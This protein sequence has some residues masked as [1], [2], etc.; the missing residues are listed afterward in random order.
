MRELTVLSC[1]VG[2]PARPGVRSICGTL[3]SGMPALD[4]AA[5]CGAL[6]VLD[7]MGTTRVV[8]VSRRHMYCSNGVRPRIRFCYGGYNGVVS[9]FSR[10]TPEMARAGIVSN[11]VIRRRRLCCG[12]VYSTYTGGVRGGA[13]WRRRGTRVVHRAESLVMVEWCGAEAFF[14]ALAL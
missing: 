14:G 13:G 3:R 5:I 11:G 6:H 8:A 4:H 10:R 12:N 7:R 2:R 9:L 1:L